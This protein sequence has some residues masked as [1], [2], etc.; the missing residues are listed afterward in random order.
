MVLC[1]DGFGGDMNR[2]DFVCFNGSGD[3][4]GDTMLWNYRL[5]ISLG[6]VGEP[7]RVWN[8]RHFVSTDIGDCVLFAHRACVLARLDD[9]GPSYDEREPASV[10]SNPPSDLPESPWQVLD[11][12]VVVLMRPRDTEGKAGSIVVP[13][14]YRNTSDCGHVLAVGPKVKGLT[15]G[16]FVLTCSCPEN[17]LLRDGQRFCIVK[18]WEIHCIGDIYESK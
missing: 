6:V 9:E 12:R 1:P 14:V 5:D 13:D 11:N 16:D 3:F 4:T 10:R 8:G 18:P 2:G 15:R 17:E 7:L